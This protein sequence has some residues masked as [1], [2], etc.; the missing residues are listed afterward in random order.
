MGWLGRWWKGTPPRSVTVGKRKI[1]LE[2]EPNAL[3]EFWMR[4]WKTLIQLVTGLVAV[5]I[6]IITLL[7]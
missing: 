7:T 3:V 6:A 4:N 1:F 2:P 5:V